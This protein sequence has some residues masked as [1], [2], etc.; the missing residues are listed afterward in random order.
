MYCV[1]E[2]SVTLGHTCYSKPLA[3][4]SHV[5]NI[6]QILLLGIFYHDKHLFLSHRWLNLQTMWNWNISAVED[7][8]KLSPGVETICNADS[9]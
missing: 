6:S 1:I 2:S 3:F 9:N 8:A 5:V 7:F 4:R